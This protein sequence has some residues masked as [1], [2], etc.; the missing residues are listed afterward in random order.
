MAAIELRFKDRSVLV[1]S[2]DPNTLSI[3]NFQ[4]TH[5]LIASN[6]SPVQPG[7]I[8]FKSQVDSD[9]HR[10]ERLTISQV[11]YGVQRFH[12]WHKLTG[13]SVLLFVQNKC[14]FQNLQENVFIPG[15]QQLIAPHYP[16]SIC[17][18]AV[19]RLFVLM[20]CL[21]FVHSPEHVEWKFGH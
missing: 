17:P 5:W 14:N 16:H 18:V 2:H 1:A 4:Y 20:L 11:N 12:P 6:S 9:L 7:G 3:D 8:N 19:H 15:L 21:K 10:H 13:K